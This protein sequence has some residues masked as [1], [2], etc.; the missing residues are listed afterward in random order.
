MDQ[1]AA[2]RWV[3]HNILFFGGNPLAVTVAGES[4]G[5]VD[6]CAQMASPK[7]GGLF[8]GAI[9]E[10]LYCP[11]TTRQAAETS[12]VQFAAAAGCGDP[13]NAEACLR[14]K[15]ASD[16]VAAG[17]QVSFNASPAAGGDVLPQLPRD[18]FQSGHWNRV[19]LL[20]GTNH[21]E[22]AAEVAAALQAAKALPLTP[23]LYLQAVD[24]SFGSNAPAVM[25]EYPLASFSSPFF[26]LVAETTD[27]GRLTAPDS[28]SASGV[29]AISA[30]FQRLSGIATTYRYEFADPGTPLPPLFPAGASIGAYHAGELQYLY[31]DTEENG[32]MTPAQR[33]LAQQMRQYWANFVAS[34]DPNGPGLPSWPVYETGLQRTLSLRPSGSQIVSNFEADHHCAFWAATLR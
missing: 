25:N 30:L 3:R 12:A 13:S 21:D 10:S 24:K 6:I 28:E 16:L 27:A 11:G 14:S 29:C 4:A 20:L 26:A 7:A 34:G 23:Q 5:A 33:R 2:L 9:L 17:Q 8:H 19:H 18:A 31:I 22:S 15:S 32:S 1:Q